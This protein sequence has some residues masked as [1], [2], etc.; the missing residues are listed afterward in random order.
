MNYHSYKSNIFNKS[1]EKEEKYMMKNQRGITLIALVITIIVLLILAG[2]SIAM[3]MGDNGIL[4][5]AQS[6]KTETLKAESVERINLA[7]NAVKTEI[8]KQQV[9]SSSWRPVTDKAAEGATEASYEFKDEA[10][11]TILSK[12]GVVESSDD[13]TANDNKYVY[14]LDPKTGILTIS[15]ANAAQEITAS[16]S[17]DLTSTDFE[18]TPATK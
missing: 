18:L 7:L 1:K 11:T 17:I 2:V 3:L 14:T 5:N 4:T 6:S 15:Y 10:I 16:G 8:Y 9:S 13:S 12:D